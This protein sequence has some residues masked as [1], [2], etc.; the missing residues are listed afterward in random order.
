V[1]ISGASVALE[2]PFIKHHEYKSVALLVSDAGTTVRMTGGNITGFLQAV[3][4]QNG[5]RFVTTPVH[6]DSNEYV[7]LAG[8]RAT[9]VATGIEVSGDGTTV[10]L[11]YSTLY[12][13]DDGDGIFGV[14]VHSNAKAMLSRVT[15][16]SFQTCFKI[17]STVPATMHRCHVDPVGYCNTGMQSPGTC[18]PTIHFLH[19]SMPFSRCMSVWGQSCVVSTI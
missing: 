2:T 5:A 9:S 13:A 3:A 1:A 15:A 6:N 7:K 14:Y 8:L 12:G 16:G 19:C 17:S 18:M 11:N 10:E 4:I